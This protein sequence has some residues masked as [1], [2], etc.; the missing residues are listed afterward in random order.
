MKLKQNFCCFILLVVLM[1][2]ASWVRSEL[3]LGQEQVMPGE[4]DIAREMVRLIKSVSLKRHSRA[5]MKRFN[6]VKTLGCFNADFKVIEGLAEHLKQGL[7]AQPL[8][9]DAL[10][11]FANAS[12][13]DDREKDLR[14][15]SVKVYGVGGESLWGQPGTQDFL[16]NSYPALFA[17]TPKDFLSFIR[18]LDRDNLAWFF[19]NPFDSHIKSLFL[20][21]KARRYHVSPFDISY[22]ST[23]PYRYGVNTNHAVK[24]SARP[25]SAV[26]TEL[27]S[28]LLGEDHQRVSMQKHLEKA[29]VCFDFMVQFQSDSNKMPIED[30]S[31]IWDEAVSP[32]Q[33]V[34]RITIKFQDFSSDAALASCEAQVFNPWQSRLEHKPLGGINRVRKYVYEEMARFRVQ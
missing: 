8:R 30:A 19:F 25:C 4:D 21:N 7:F 17:A 32:F 31:V 23:T 3:E 12:K 10:V 26:K 29:P 5:E 6:Q 14:G 13:F 24:Y 20:L 34:A 33:T 22:W 11:R 2:L 1:C 28:Q 9:Y 18:A 16:F 15:L 27:P